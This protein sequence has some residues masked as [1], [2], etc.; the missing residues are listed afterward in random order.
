MNTNVNAINSGLGSVFETSRLRDS[1]TPRCR[2]SYRTWNVGL[3]SFEVA[4]LYRD[5]WLKPCNVPDER[6]IQGSKGHKQLKAQQT[7]AEVSRR[8]SRGGKPE[9]WKIDR[10]EDGKGNWHLKSSR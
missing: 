7:K 9:D 5:E 3:G 1:E 2:S 10:V 8:R 6:R 4:V